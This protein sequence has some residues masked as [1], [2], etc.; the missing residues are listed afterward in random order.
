MSHDAPPRASAFAFKASTAF[1]S[2]RSRPAVPSVSQLAGHVA[3][4][5]GWV[6]PENPRWP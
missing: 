6:S 4:T 1:C 2:P 5:A 3:R